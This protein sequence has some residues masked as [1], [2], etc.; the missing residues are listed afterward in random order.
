MKVLKIFRSKQFRVIFLI[1]GLVSFWAGPVHSAAVN[2]PPLAA[3]STSIAH[4]DGISTPPLE[5]VS[6]Q[7]IWKHQFKFAGFYAAIEQ[8]FY[9]EK[10]LE[11]E[12]RE[13]EQ[14]LDVLDEVLSGR[15]TYGVANG[16]VIGWRLEGQ[17]VV[18]LANYFKKVPLVLLGRPGIRTL[19]DLKGRRLMTADTDLESPLLRSALRETGLTL[20][21]NL[22]IAPHTFDTGPF[23]RGEVEA[24]TA[25]ISNQ[26]FDLEQRGMPFQI[27]ELTSY[28]PG[29]G[30]EYL[31]TAS[32]EASSHLERT[33]VFIEASNQGWRYALEHHDEIVDLILKRYSQRK[34]EEALHYEA[35]KTRQQILPKSF[36]VGSLSSQRIELAA[37]S[38][39]DSGHAGDLRH[40]EGFLFEQDA[41]EAKSAEVHAPVTLTSEERVWLEAHPRIVLGMSDQFPPAV[42]RNADG[43]LSGILADLLELLNRRLGTRITLQVESSW[44][45]V[46]EQAI[47]GKLDGLAAVAPVPIWRQYFNLTTPY[48]YSHISLYMTK[49]DKL[50]KLW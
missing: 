17:P 29:L 33:R 19:D 27:I 16:S 25:F 8:G 7:L 31:F 3:R 32:A 22:S 15:A 21:Q 45:A 43:K 41:S 42:I 34:S 4:T 9:R 30:D 2:T 35:E 12:L 28:M 6:L 1:L 49:K 48:L 13:Y 20:G 10:G 44:Q 37:R 40:L 39:L 24:M 5:K 46:S 47:R 23:I 14:G 50:L 11:I 36:P 26:P 18:L 38:F